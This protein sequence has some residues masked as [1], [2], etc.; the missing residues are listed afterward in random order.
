M[1][2]MTLASGVTMFCGVEPPAKAGFPNDQVAFLFGEILQRHD[3]NDF[4]KR[5]VVVGGKLFEQWLQFGNKS[6]DFIFRN[7]LPVNFEFVPGK[8][9]DAVR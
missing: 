4:K 9:P 6:D 8:K 5:R 3:R 2:V 7:E 1:L